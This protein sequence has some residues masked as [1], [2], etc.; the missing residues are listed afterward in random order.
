MKTLLSK[1]MILC[2]SLFCIFFYSLVFCQ[3]PVGRIFDTTRGQAFT[4]YNDGMAVQ[5]GNPANRG[6]TMRD[7]SGVMFLRL[8]AVN[9]YRNAYFLDYQGRFFEVDIEFGTRQIGYYDF[10]PPQNPYQYIPPVYSRTIGIQTPQGFQPLPQ[11]IADT[12]N[13]YGNLM[14]TSEQVANDCYRQSLDFSNHL[15]QRKFGDCMVSNM[16]GSREN[17]MYNCVKNSRNPSEQAL[18]MVGSMGG[19]NERRISQTLLR[20][21]QEFGTDYTKYTLCLAGEAADPDLQRLLSCVKDQASIG[22]V[23]FMNTAM[24]YGASKL[25]LNTESQIIAQCAVSSGGQPYVFAGC[26]GGQL[27]AMELNKCLTNGIGGNNGCFGP[28]NTIMQGLNSI[29]NALQGQF[30]PT[31]DIVKTWNNT[32]NDIRNGPGKNHEA[33]KIIR[34]ISNET[35][36]AA[37]NVGREVGKVFSKIKF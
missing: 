31:N 22:Q 8:P 34:N 9:P 35:G 21:Y 15:D 20:C 12:N 32:V 30:G 33:V 16:M 7:P 27:T 23:S 19:P 28:N 18:C 24:C 14:I 4:L 26:A 37:N 36:K 1:Q 6:M 2:V 10:Q 13:P 3:V 17:E 11:Q 5:V 25:N 29:G